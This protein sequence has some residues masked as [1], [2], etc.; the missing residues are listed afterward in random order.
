MR[1][2]AVLRARQRTR[3]PRDAGAPFQPCPAAARTAIAETVFNA[4]RDIMDSR[5]WCGH[6]K[7]ERPTGSRS[8]SQ[9]LYRPAFQRR[10]S[11]RCADGD[12][13]SGFSRHRRTQRLTYYFCAESCLERF[14]QNPDDSPSQFVTIDAVT[15][16]PGARVEYTCP[17]D[18]EIIRDRPGACPICGMALEP[19]VITLDDRPNPE[20]VSMTRRFWISALLPRRFS[21]SR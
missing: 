18:P 7:S 1:P 5:Y 11:T 16:P 20:L 17:M 19:R 15:A 4:V 2:I 3:L 12:R 14:K 6:V 8:N 21:R 9:E 10:I 13:R